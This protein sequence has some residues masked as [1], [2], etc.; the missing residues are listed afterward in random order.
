MEI[1]RYMPGEIRDGDSVGDLVDQRGKITLL[2]ISEGEWG[3][4]A[5]MGDMEQW[6]DQFRGTVVQGVEMTVLQESDIRDG[7][8]EI[9][10]TEMVP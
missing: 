6:R 4:R 3:S 5:M 8:V 2:K 9:E 1:W 7:D 10:G